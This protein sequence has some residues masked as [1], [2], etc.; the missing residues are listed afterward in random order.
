MLG[1]GWQSKQVKLQAATQRH[2]ATAAAACA[3]APNGCAHFIILVFCDF[4]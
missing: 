4:R 1:R 3:A 2:Q